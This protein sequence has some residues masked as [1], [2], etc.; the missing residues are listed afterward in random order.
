MQSDGKEIGFW[1]AGMSVYGV[2]EFLANGVLFMKYNVHNMEGIIIII[3]MV[4]AYF[5][6]YAIF[7]LFPG[8]IFHAFT[9]NMSILLVWLS[10]FVSVG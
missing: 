7:N 6:F 4:A 8:Y 10:F 9:T 3:L 2:C 5:V 1:I